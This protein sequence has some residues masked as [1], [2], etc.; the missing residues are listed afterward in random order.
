VSSSLLW[1]QTQR[2]QNRLQQSAPHEL[3]IASGDLIE[4]SV[5]GAEYSCSQDKIAG[6]QVR[7]SSSGEVALPLIGAA[8]MAGLT[9]PQAQQLIAQRLK[10]GGYFKDPQV[11]VA[12]KEFNTQGI[13]VLG[14]VQ[15]PGI[16]PLLGAHTL[17]EALSAAGGTT[18]AAG[19][20]VSIMH[21]DSP[22]VA[23]RVNLAAADG[24]NVSLQP[25]DTVLVSKA[26]VVYVVG[27]V[28][29]PS[30]V[31]MD[32]AGLTV[33]Q[34]IAMAQGAN[35]TAKLDSAKLIRTTPEGRKEIPL[36]LKQILAS[37]APDLRLQAEDIIFVPTSTAKSA[38]RRSL[39][40]IVQTATG[41]AIYRR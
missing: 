19:N 29:Q 18:K 2:N 33:L 21:R 41:V 3:T 16:Y 1:G 13:S 14:E 11:M 20:D 32:N 28:K 15:K 37:K 7:V 12:Q 30:G 24:G 4:V 9:T 27:D 10:E 17:L 31:V 5:F 40:A 25:G 23:E 26:G 36:A 8:K 6:C 39:E 22:N 38:T 35:P 34:A